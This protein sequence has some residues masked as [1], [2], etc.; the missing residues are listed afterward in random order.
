MSNITALSQNRINIARLELDRYYANKAHN[1]THGSIIS[2]YLTKS[3]ASSI[4]SFNESVK[5]PYGNILQAHKY[6]S[7]GSTLHYLAYNT[8]GIV[9]YYNVSIIKAQPRLA[10]KVNG[11]VMAMPNSIS[12]IHVPVLKGQKTYSFS[13]SLNSSI[14]QGNNANYSYEIKFSNGTTI[15]KN[16][17][18]SAINYSKTFT[19]Y[20]DQNATI[21]F[22][23]NGNG[24]YTAVDPTT[25]VIPTEIVYYA[26]VTLTNSQTTPTPAPFQ[27]ELSVNSLAYN[28]Y[29]ANNLNNIEFFYANGNIIPSWM[30]GSASNALLNNPSNSMYLYTSTNT[31]Y[32]LNISSGIPADS[33]SISIYMGFA[34]AST[35]LLNNVNVG[36]EPQISSTYGQYDDGA[37]VFGNYFAGNSLSGWTVAGSAGLASNPA[38][39]GSPFGAN[40]FYA[41]GSNGDYLNTSANGQSANMIIEYYTDTATLEDVF[42]LTDSSGAGQMGRLGNGGSWYG[43][44]ST[45]SWTSWSGP[46]D[47]GYW[48]NEWVLASIVVANNDATM[49]VSPDPGIY[50]SEI[51]QNA[52]NTYAAADN[53]NFLGLIGD[54]GGGVS[55]W[56]GFI[57]RAY[58]PNGIMPSATFGS[59]LPANA[60]VINLQSNPVNYGAASTITA[61]SETSGDS[62]EIEESGNV[63]AGPAVNTI[64]YTICGTTPSLANCWAPGNYIITANDITNGDSSNDILTVDKGIPTLSLPATNIIM[65]SGGSVSINYGISTVGNQ[66]TANLI[67]DGTS[68]SSTTSNSNTYSLSLSS[69]LHTLEV[70]TAG[71]GNYVSSNIIRQYCVVPT[72]SQLP[73]DV[74]HYAPLCVI[75]NQS[76][77]TPAPF[78]TMINI[79][80]NAYPN[81]IAY[82]GN[83][84]NFEV[85]GATGAVQPAWIESNSS[86]KL[87]TWVKLATS[88]GA[89]SISPLYLGF[90]ANTFNMLSNTGTS[91]IGENPTATSTYG[92]YDDGA[93]VFNLYDNFAGTSLNPNL[94]TNYTGSG[95]ITVDNSLTISTTGAGTILFSKSIFSPNIIGEAYIISASATSMRSAT[96]GFS[97]SNTLTTV[98][99]D[100]VASPTVQWSNGGYN[101]GDWMGSQGDST[102]YTQLPT[103]LS[104]TGTLNWFLGV[105]YTSTTDLFYGI[106]KSDVPTPYSNFTSSS[107]DMPTGNVYFSLGIG[108][109]G[110][111]SGNIDM[112]Y[113]RVRAYPPNGI[114]P[115]ILFGNVS[116]SVSS[117]QNTC[118]ISLSTSAINFANVGPGNNIAATNAVTDDNTGNSNAYM[119]IYGGNWIGP[120]QFGVSNTIWAPSS[121]VPFASANMLSAAPEN[122]LLLVPSSGSNTIYFGLGVP[123][124]TPAGY[125]SQNIMI[126]NSC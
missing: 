49:Y 71:N 31:I 109:G 50:G 17:T 104:S 35:S 113:T 55:Y 8:H 21:T 122:T 52:S 62:V 25:I 9:T 89:N 15:S 95:A 20:T 108:G 111:T 67:A 29:E 93:G 75:N 46:P 24:N 32:W 23:T 73:N 106:S 90:A 37:D 19:L 84:A 74:S 112:Q 102:A 7:A 91:G 2:S 63:I 6:V 57:I 53:G 101:N 87:I 51:G 56:N 100:N 13:L 70:T 119:Y 124:G 10:I 27:Q 16:I 123:A 11:A 59:V 39:S 121:G 33:N 85:F 66:L 80:E 94:W 110:V 96:P 14:A 5:V 82:N 44:A 1:K 3:N 120:A 18:A 38:P 4:Y 105:G 97:T 65:S 26:P 43:I 76:T 40:A 88:I 114:M 48:Q 28:T 36:E 78:Q 68:V 126:E 42:F 92:Q 72:P 118:T 103:T 41:D 64:D 81:Y 61:T 54:G 125:Y 116:S 45:S 12:I 99:A 117:T 77:S 58:P 86:G 69:G 79:T 22:D 98:G 60:P 83:L 115:T 30:E 107:T 47:T 34:S